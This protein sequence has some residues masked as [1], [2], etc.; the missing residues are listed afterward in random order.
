MI[1]KLSPS[2]YCM[3]VSYSPWHYFTFRQTPSI[4]NTSPVGGL[5]RTR[6]G[7]LIGPGKIEG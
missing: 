3:R 1:L 7:I 6:D 5:D 2:G 4:V